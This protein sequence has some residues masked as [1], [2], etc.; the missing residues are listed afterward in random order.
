M[1]T[2]LHYIQLH[3]VGNISRYIS[4]ELRETSICEIEHKHHHT[5]YYTGELKCKCLK[6]ELC[7]S[8]MYKDNSKL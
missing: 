5:L 3:D 8:H 7:F 4:R 2:Q 1:F 6:L